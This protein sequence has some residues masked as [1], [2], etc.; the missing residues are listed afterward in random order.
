M[1]TV[2]PLLTLAKELAQR[3][4]PFIENQLGCKVNY[5]PRMGPQLQMI[6]NNKPF[7]SV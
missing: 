1:A 4:G 2:L 5:D 7:Y 3:T 6:T